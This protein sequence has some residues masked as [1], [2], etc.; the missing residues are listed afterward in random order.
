MARKLPEL[1]EKLAA[2]IEKA[3]A[4]PQAASISLTNSSPSGGNLRAILFSCTSS[5]CF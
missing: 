5:A 2:E 3:W 4:Q 1:G